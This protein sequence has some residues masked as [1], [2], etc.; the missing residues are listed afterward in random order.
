MVASL[1]TQQRSTRNTTSVQIVAIDAISPCP[2]NEELY[3]PVDPNDRDIQALAASIREGGVREPLVIT[4]DHV[5]LS[6]HRRQTAALLAG[7]TE[8][9]CRIEPF[10]YC[11]CDSDEIL[12]LLREHNRQRVKSLEEMLREEVVS[13]DPAEAYDRLLEHREQRSDLSDL[14]GKP[15]KTVHLSARRG[16]KRISDRKQEMLDAALRV[17]EERREYWPLSDR[18]IHYVLLNDPPRRNTLRKNSRYANDRSSYGDLCDL[19]T[20]ARLAGDIPW[21][22]I[23]DDTR[24]TTRWRCYSNARD[25]VREELDGLFKNYARDLQR[26]Q[27]NHIEI[28]AE[29]LTVRNIVER[30]AG[31]YGLPVTIGRGYCSIT[32]RYEMARRFRRSGKS[33][34]IVLMLSDF[35]PDGE[36]IAESFAR[37]MRDDF[38]IDALVPIKVALTAEQALDLGLKPGMQAKKSSRQYHKFTHQYG[39]DVFELE[40]VPPDGLQRLLTEAIESV[41]DVEGFNREIDAEREDA[42]FLEEARQRARLALRQVSEDS[43][44]ED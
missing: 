8:V 29:K 39:N 5:I 44:H 20:R 14:S 12:L 13:V 24:P 15:L 9:P 4:Q 25:F 7:L 2:E 37:S 31:R 43:S 36:A 18:Q 28:V 23:A 21:C 17:I 3:R 40:A 16:R 22:A 19:L 10:R 33:H 6:G 34:L 26:S 27:P 1:K 41:L 32:P 42:A 38:N 30:V 35:D 11:D